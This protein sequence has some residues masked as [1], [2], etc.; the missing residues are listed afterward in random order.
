MPRQL[1]KSNCL[2]VARNKSLFDDRPEEF[3]ALAATIKSDLAGL[4]RRIQDLK[5]EQERLSSR[6]Q[7]AGRT[8]QEHWKNV[9]TVLQT[10]AA[11]AF[12]SYEQ[13]Q[14]VRAQTLKSKNDR[15]DQFGASVL[16][17]ASSANISVLDDASSTTRAKSPFSAMATTASRQRPML[18]P[19]MVN[20]K[21][22]HVE[23][24]G[25]VN[26]PSNAYHDHVAIDF[27]GGEQ[28]ALLQQ[29]HQMDPSTLR[30]RANALG[31]IEATINELGTIYSQLAHMVAQQGDLVQRIDMNI[32]D[33]GLNVQM[34]QTQLTRYLRRVS[35]N[36]WLI[37]KIFASFI[38]FII[39]FKF[40]F[41]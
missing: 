22:A 37:A 38:L 31:A 35:S 24:Y 25:A 6:L 21:A 14:D 5:A 18:D 7:T 12:K 3:N 15:R 39:I 26:S 8:A 29:Q 11:Q 10:R 13:T 19:S 4:S 16:E 9:A 20:V 33:M 30:S 27:N 17:T 40:L 41:L 32:E 23:G 28:Q 36:R 34:G 1:Q 2:V